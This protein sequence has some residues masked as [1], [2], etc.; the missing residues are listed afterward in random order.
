MWI[1]CIE[2][3]KMRPRHR[4][5]LGVTIFRTSFYR[6][7]IRTECSFFFETITSFQNQNYF[8][9]KYF[10][11]CLSFDSFNSIQTFSLS[12]ILMSS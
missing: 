12:V 10:K 3:S 7:C 4:A 9:F 2:N 6:T 1:N 5:V 11:F 8:R